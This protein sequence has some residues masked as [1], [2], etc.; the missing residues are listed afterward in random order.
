MLSSEIDLENPQ[1]T[2]SSSVLDNEEKNTSNVTPTD[3]YVF[4]VYFRFIPFS[5]SFTLTSSNKPDFSRV[6]GALCVSGAFLGV[7]STFGQVNSFGT[8][9]A[10]YGQNQLAHRSSSAISWIG[11]SQLCTF[12]LAVC[13][14][15]LRINDPLKFGSIKGWLIG[16]LFDAYGP[17]MLMLT[18]TSLAVLSLAA[19]SFARTYPEFIVTHGVLFGLGSAFMSVLFKLFCS[20]ANSG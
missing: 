2:P 10:W 16:R 12:F 1:S 4:R 9:Q 5:H 20:L 17:R 11:S 18:G 19:T 15:H 13:V 7:F 14:S 6:K 8:F 3:R